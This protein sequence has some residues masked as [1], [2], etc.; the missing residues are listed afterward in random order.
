M[1]R[2]MAS[3]VSRLMLKPN[4][5]M[6]AAAPISDSGMVTSGISTVRSEPR[7]RKITTATMITASTRVLSTSSI[8]AWMKRATSKTMFA[9]MP[10]GMFSRTCGIRSLTPW[11]MVSGL[12]VGVGCRPMNTLGSPSMMP[13]VSKDVAPSSAV[14][15]SLRRIRVS[16]WVLTT[17]WRNC[18]TLVR[19][20]LTLM[21]AETYWPLVWPGA[22]WK[23]LLRI[24]SATS[25]A[26]MLRAAM[27][28]GSSHRRMA[29]FCPPR[30]CASATPSTEANSGCTTREI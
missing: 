19:S 5:L 18:S 26:E 25:L 9:V 13:L 27:R 30:I 21:L 6:I 23:L 15:I 29:S 12:P 16:P 22:A 1:A 28:A 24:A 14:P 3:R 8:D 20:V 17:I 10:G 11:T 4:R 2:T 7:N